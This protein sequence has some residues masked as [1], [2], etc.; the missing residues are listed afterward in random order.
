MIHDI[1][2]GSFH[3]RECSGPCL[4]TG[5][6]RHL[7]RI[8]RYLFEMAVLGNNSYLVLGGMMQ[9]ALEDAGVNPHLFLI[10]AKQGAK[11][12]TE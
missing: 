5:E 7:T 11:P 8:V 3:C 2:D 4:L 12:R 6:A 9:P 1:F 10:R